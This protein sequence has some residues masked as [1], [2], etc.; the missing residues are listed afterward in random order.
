[1]IGNSVITILD[2]LFTFGDL[3][4]ML[5]LIRGLPGCFKTEIAESLNHH[6]GFTHFEA[7]QRIK[8]LYGSL[9]AITKERLH[10]AHEWCRMNCEISLNKNQ[11]TV[12]A[13]VFRNINDLKPYIILGKR[14]LATIKILSLL[15]ISYPPRCV[16][17]LFYMNTAVNWESCPGE[18]IATY[19]SVRLSLPTNGYVLS[20]EHIDRIL[21]H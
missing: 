20:N 1:M 2:D 9:S 17:R 21:N 5:F 4:M 16:D 14:A 7:D 13:N 19:Y 18:I 15:P 11:D 3:V 8:Q 6:H 10:E 12:I